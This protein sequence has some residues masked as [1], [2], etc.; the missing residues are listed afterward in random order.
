MG[1]I[2]ELERQSELEAYRALLRRFRRL[3]VAGPE[4]H[5]FEDRVSQLWRKLHPLCFAIGMAGSLIGIIFELGLIA[6]GFELPMGRLVAFHAF[7]SVTTTALVLL[8]CRFPNINQRL[9]V[10]TTFFQYALYH[11]IVAATVDLALSHSLYAASG[12]LTVAAMGFLPARWK[13]ALFN[14]MTTALCFSLGYVAAT[15]GS[16]QPVSF[17]MPVIFMLVT[18]PLVVVMGSVGL[19]FAQESSFRANRALDVAASK[20]H[21]A[22]QAK[23]DFLA[24]MSHEIRTPMNGVIGMTELLMDTPLNQNQAEYAQT[25]RSCGES[26]LGIIND[27][28][29]F[30]KIEAGKLK[31]E[32][33]PFHLRDNLEEVIDLLAFQAQK[34]NL[35]L[36]LSMSPDVPQALLG[37]GGRLRQILINLI[38]NAI[39]FTS[40]G[41][42][43][44]QVRVA[45]RSDREVTIR[46]GVRD[47]GIGIAAEKQ[48]NLFD[49][50]SQADSSTTRKFGGTGLGLSISKK[51]TKLMK[52]DIGVVSKSGKGS[53]FW[54][55]ARFGLNFESV[56]QPNDPLGLLA[57]VRILIV[58]HRQAL[59]RILNRE[60]RACKALPQC[61]SNSN[62]AW[63]IL[64]SVNSLFDLFDL[65]ILGIDHAEDSNLEFARQI[66]TDSRYSYLPIL[67]IT[68]SGLEIP[69]DP[70]PSAGFVKKLAKP[71]RQRHLIESSLKAIGLS[72]ELHHGLDRNR[73]TGKTASQAKA[74]NVARAQMRLLVVEDNL[75]N[76][77]LA[78]K[79]LSKLGYESVIAHN[80]RDALE[81]F[82]AQSFHGI[83]MDCQMPEMDGFEATRAIR[84]QESPTHR[85]PIIAMTAN[86]MKG[87]RELTLAA[88]MD[89][90]LSKPVKPETLQEVL[91]S[92]VRPNR[93]YGGEAIRQ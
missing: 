28:L 46:F 48:T 36:M 49:S 15:L 69:A 31:L 23:A 45:E 39:K 62:E 52:G 90:Y 89:D 3:W 24:N 79:L 27:I 71:I 66:R 34:K 40:Q 53:L 65:I 72:P 78:V 77:K 1:R 9:L 32:A 2:A 55:T 93:V 35:E 67:F 54:F 87:D 37:D 84:H 61:C 19:Y 56:E 63:E 4:A 43:A 74:A 68:P 92:W 58:N 17:Y 86:A 75:V 13:G 30:S 50:F 57:G 20:A 12:Y 91:E 51:L 29:D 18:G 25:I 80:G 88:G 70:L 60:L 44:V 41:Y 73:Q 38:G 7:S 22:A 64:H 10:R 21:S 14:G 5:N 11:G 26:L 81:K 8:A 33:I 59:Q 82:A 42:V 83:L 6:S 76:Q 16:I 85:I 47:T